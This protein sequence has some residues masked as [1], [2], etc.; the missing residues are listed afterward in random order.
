MSKS[1][2]TATKPAFGASQGAN[3]LEQHAFKGYEKNPYELSYKDL[4]LD[5]R[6]VIRILSFNTAETR[7]AYKRK[8]ELY[9]NSQKWKGWINEYIPVALM[10]KGDNQTPQEYVYV[11]GQPLHHDDEFLSKLKDHKDTP[12]LET[13][14][15]RFYRIPVWVYE[16]TNAKGRS[17]EIGKLAFVELNEFMKNAL[18]QLPKKNDGAFE[19]NPQTGMP[20]FDIEIR[21]ITGQNG[22][23]NY[24]LAGIQGRVTS[25]H[26]NYG[27]PTEKALSEYVELINEEWDALQE[28]MNA[29]W[30]KDQITRKLESAPSNA[31]SSRPMLSDTQADRVEELQNAVGEDSTPTFRFGGR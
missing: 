4:A 6:F 17:E 25:P 14:V 30:T 13:K 26:P 20:D 28:H 3:L 21:A 22:M 1:V 9:I 5:E 11:D 10:W 16:K 23:K 19:F 18:I 27:V 31:L 29:F 2:A 12:L 24:E 8:V 15:S 7:V